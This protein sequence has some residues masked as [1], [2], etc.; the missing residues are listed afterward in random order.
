MIKEM[1]RLERVIDLIP[2]FKVK[3]NEDF[4]KNLEMALDQQ[5]RFDERNKLNLIEI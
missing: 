3:F 4:D 2:L 5:Q 1:H